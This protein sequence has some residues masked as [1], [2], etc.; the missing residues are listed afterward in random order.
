MTEQLPGITV[1]LNE[2]R[3]N[4]V[5]E[6]PAA[7]MPYIRYQ[8]RVM[9]VL[10]ADAV[11]C[12]IA[13]NKDGDTKASWIFKAAEAAVVREESMRDHLSK[14]LYLDD[15]VPMS[16]FDDDLTSFQRVVVEMDKPNDGPQPGHVD[17]ETGEILEEE[18]PRPP[19][20]RSPNGTA[21]KVPSPRPNG[22]S[23]EIESYGRPVQ[24]KDKALAA[25][26]E[27]DK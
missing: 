20:F 23:S 15:V 14:T 24:Y 8:E 13:D 3:L 6:L 22:S 1:H 19:L 5:F 11:K 9:L 18:K 7:D 4:G 21:H 12:N 2:G 10:L 16:L 26:M 27:E 25:F 17:E